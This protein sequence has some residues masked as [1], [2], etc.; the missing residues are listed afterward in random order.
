MTFFRG[1]ATDLRR[2]HA[3]LRRR[4]SC[5]GRRATCSRP[6]RS[7]AGASSGSTTTT[8]R[9]R[10]SSRCARR[11][12]PGVV[13]VTAGRR[14]ARCRRWC[15]LCG[16]RSRFTDKLV[17]LV[18]GSLHPARLG[19]LGPALVV[20]GSASWQAARRAPRGPRAADRG[21]ALGP[22]AR[23]ERAAGAAARPRRLTWVASRDFRLV[24]F[25]G[26]RDGGGRGARGARSRPASGASRERFGAAALARC[27]A[28]AQEAM[29]ARRRRGDHAARARRRSDGR[30]PRRE[31]RLGGGAVRRRPRRPLPHPRPRAPAGASRRSWSPRSA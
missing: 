15:A 23:G 29:R 1:V 20:R 27:G 24:H 10:I 31:A 22:R 19:A 25:G 26:L 21:P 8:G 4:A 7:T 12:A 16:R 18:S 13:H 5:R 3:D 2:E 14:A 28:R 6:R 17:D 30:A 11:S 9:P